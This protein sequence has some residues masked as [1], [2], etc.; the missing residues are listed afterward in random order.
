MSKGDKLSKDKAKVPVTSDSRFKSVHN[1]PRFKTP[2]LKNLKIKVDDRFSEKVLLKLNAGATGKKVKIDRYGR[3]I[4]D[5]DSI[6]KLRKFYEHEDDQTGSESED[7]DEDEEQAEDGKTKKD[8][9]SSDEETS[10]EE[11]GDENE[12]DKEMQ[13]ALKLNPAEQALLDRRLK[14]SAKSEKSKKLSDVSATGSSSS[15][16]ELSSSDQESSSDSE[17]DSFGEFSEEEFSDIEIE[18]KPE[19]GD[20]TS[21]FAVVNMDWDNIRAVDLMATFSSFVPKGGLIKSVKIYPSEFGK[22]QM[23]KE[24]IE[25]P[26]KELFKSKKKK[27]V[28]SDSESDIDEEDLKT[29][30]GMEKAARLLYKEDDGTEDYDS[31]ALRRYQ[32]QRLRYYYAVV[33]CDSVET[34]SN[35]Y[36]NCDGTEFES[37]ANIFDLRYVPE[38]MEFD[39][40]EPTD[41]CVEIPTSYNPNSTFV[42]D[43]LQHSKVKLTWDE[44]PRERLKIA[45]K[46]FSQREIDE[47]DFKAYLASDSDDSGSDK[48]ENIDKYKSLLG[49]K[50]SS[51][52]KK[53]ENSEDDIDMEITFNPGLD[54]NAIAEQQKREEELN[55]IEAYKQKEKERRKKRMNKLKE[56]QKDTTDEETKKN[57]KSKDK[58]PKVDEKSKAELELLMMDEKDDDAK[59]DHFN[60]KDIIKQEK[61]KNKLSKKK[62]KSVD[63]EMT[64]DNFE[65]DLND[66]RFKEIFENHEFAIDPTSSEFKKTQ[67]MKK[68][69]KERSKRKQ[70]GEGKSDTK[71]RNTGVEKSIES[72]GSDL[73]NLVN[74]LKNKSKTK[75]ERT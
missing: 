26:P 52:D 30:E 38:D 23:Q 1:D 18:E 19:E 2:N 45:N 9:E 43:A 4:K 34:A 6:K 14:K 44:T 20:P 28:E 39:D 54:E 66:P 50:F 71:R 69:L 16:S 41:T 40:T 74:K 64:Q 36:K 46:Q 24:E 10:D 42:T 3:K 25:G 75:K 72:N 27:A 73:T 63:K 47:M 55:T 13:N 32:L 65:A 5:D 37:T 67:T 60:M 15:E 12:E 57:S 56:S 62:S 22:E 35:I 29:A 61:M 48:E 53:G 59:L 68:I 11:S 31:K 8:E 33:Q 7:E 51:F 49:N 58:K 70:N 17:S 21:A